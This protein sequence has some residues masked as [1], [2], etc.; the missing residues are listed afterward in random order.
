MK[1]IDLGIGVAGIKW[2]HIEDDRGSLDRIWDSSLFDDLNE[3]KQ[4]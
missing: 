3:F 4:V 2:T 1:I